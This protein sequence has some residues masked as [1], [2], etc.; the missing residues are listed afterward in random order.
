MSDESIEEVVEVTE[1]P[2]EASIIVGR[3]ETLNGFVE[4]IRAN[5][6]RVSLSIGDPVYQGD[7]IQTGGDG[8]IGVVFLDETLFSMK[9]FMMHL[10]KPVR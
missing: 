8:A 1:A 9:S 5:G 10:H 6:E 3:V 2:A 4:I 7:V